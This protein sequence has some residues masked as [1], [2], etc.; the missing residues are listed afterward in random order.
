VG[1]I[2]AVLLK[3]C[4]GS[5]CSQEPFERYV[6]SARVPGRIVLPCAPVNRLTPNSCLNNVLLFLLAKE[7]LRL[8][9]PGRI[10][11]P[12]FVSFDPVDTT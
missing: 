12:K 5:C 6:C 10:I 4:V 8:M 2:N 7:M 9:Y 11:D 1:E 3:T